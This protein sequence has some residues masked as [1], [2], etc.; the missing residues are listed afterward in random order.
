MRQALA[1]LLHV[2]LAATIA[3]AGNVIH[4]DAAATGSMRDGSSW[5]NAFTDLQDAID[6]AVAGDDVWVA[7]GT[8]VPRFPSSLDVRLGTIRLKSGVAVF[9]GFSGIE[10]ARGNR[11][12]SLNETILN[13]D[14]VQDD[15]ET[16]F[17]SY[18]RPW[19]ACLNSTVLMPIDS[20]IMD[21][22]VV[23]S[24]DGAEL[25]VMFSSDLTVATAGETFPCWTN[26]LRLA[27]SL[28]PRTL[29]SEPGVTELTITFS[30]PIHHFALELLPLDPV[31][32][33]LT[34]TF[35]NQSTVVGVTSLDVLGGCE[36]ESSARFFAGTTESGQFTHVAV[37]GITGSAGVAIAQMRYSLDPIER[38]CNN[39]YRIVSAAGVNDATI[40]DGFTLTAGRG[41]QQTFPNEGGGGIYITGSS[42]TVANC[43]FVD[44]MADQ[45]GGLHARDGDSTVTDC[46]FIGNHAR[47]NGGGIYHFLG[48]LT[49]NN[50]DIVSNSAGSGGGMSATGRITL[51]DSR[52]AGNTTGTLSPNGAGLL[53][54]ASPGST[55]TRCTFTNN[56][57][58]R[59]G[60]AMFLIGSPVL[61]ECDFID[62]FARRAGGA[63]YIQ[64]GS[65]PIFQGC[66]FRENESSNGPGVYIINNSGATFSDCLFE[67]NTGG[68]GGGVYAPA[69]DALTFNRCVFRGNIV[70]DNGGALCVGN[71]T[72]TSCLLTGNIALVRG[73]AA[74]VT[75]DTMINNCT[76]SAN[77]SLGPFARRG[78]MDVAAFTG[79]ALINN[80]ILWGNIDPSGGSLEASQIAADEGAVVVNH[81]IVEGWTGDLDGMGSIGADPGFK[82][83]AGS[84]GIPGT[85]D[86]DLRLMPDSP[87]INTGSPAFNPQPGETDLDGLPRIRG[88]RVDMG[89]HE[90]DTLQLTDD[91][92]ANE[93]VD[94]ADV[95]AFQVCFGGASGNPDWLSTCLCV[96]DLADDTNI[97]LSDLA[98]LVTTLS[99]AGP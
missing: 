21:G 79:T 57:I 91:F 86:D 12:P 96:F 51:I 90:T 35:M 89:A 14:I 20:S 65:H 77:A 93:R 81:S 24:I 85:S 53:L 54:N 2:G 18:T 59:D 9:G 72:M 78:G 62:N 3:R 74:S 41:R 69:G 19:S 40:L 50:C 30:T 64:F 36:P 73:G 39:V 60:G 97:D 56:S 42:M 47:A 43:L 52:F 58:N 84:D 22:E 75:G 80:S 1:L 63:A 8:Y 29:F 66:S 99:T 67:A 44:N 48:S 26:D 32:H 11:Q 70:S 25:T 98:A 45:G 82:N 95:A 16:E 23:S 71:A 13:G 6:Q 88:C 7:K 17:F 5:A 33:S 38:D 87:A 31:S 55:L 10:T 34:A 46:R 61:T 27:S 92:D 76:I 94:L 15:D 83:P 49:V 28:I 4:V 68:R 37:S